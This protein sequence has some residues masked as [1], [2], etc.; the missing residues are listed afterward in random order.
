[1][2]AHPAIDAQHPVVAVRVHVTAETGNLRAVYLDRTAVSEGVGNRASAQRGAA[3]LCHVHSVPVV[4][5]KAVEGHGARV[6]ERR[7]A[8]VV[9]FRVS[10][11]LV[12]D[13]GQFD[14]RTGLVGENAI[15]GLP[16]YA[17]QSSCHSFT[18]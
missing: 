16:E 12:D 5:C 7:T 18:G 13:V 11:Y 3:H 4:G 15:D 10:V 8:L 2:S 9:R 17:P 6:E 1:M 14:V